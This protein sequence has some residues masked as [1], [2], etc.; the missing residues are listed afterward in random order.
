MSSGG[1]LRCVVKSYC[2]D[3][4]FILLNSRRYISGKKRFYKDVSVTQSDGKFEINLDGR[5]LKTP[6]GNV[7]QVT[8][9]ALAVTVATEWDSQQSLIQQNR[10]HLTALS[11]TAIDNPTKKTKLDLVDS[12]LSSLD[13]DT[14]CFRCSQPDELKSLQQQNWDPVLQWFN[15]RYEVNISSSYEISGPSIQEKCRESVRRHLLS[16]ND[17]SLFG[18]Q[19]S[20]EVIKS[21]TLTLAAIDRHLQV[22]EAVR[23][24]RLELDFQISHWGNV[25]WAHDV[26]LMD[27]R[28]RFAAAV[29]FTHFNSEFLSS[30][31][32]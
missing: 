20:V 31:K 32:R 5:K 4:N 22:E 10:M 30:K 15:S 7:F 8:S 29:L 9:E 26:D 6:L 24:S 18:I 19:Y 1:F 13:T 2:I 28:S 23:L 14:I 25:E 12:V 11:N 16:Y 27:T 3:S 17:W 21:V